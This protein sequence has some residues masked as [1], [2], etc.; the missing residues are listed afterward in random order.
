ML[1]VPME[2]R[3]FAALAASRPSALSIAVILVTLI[4]AT[5]LDCK[6][7]TFVIPG[8]LAS[9]EGDSSSN[10]SGLFGSAAATIQFQIT[11]PEIAVLGLNPG[12]QITGVR[13][14]LNG[15][16]ATAPASDISISS[17][18]ITLAQAALPF[19]SISA[20]FA[21]NLLKPVLVRSGPFKIPAGSMP[22][23][24]TPN[25]FGVL[26][27]FSTPYTYQG[28]DLVVMYT[29][30]TVS[31]T[32][33]ADAANLYAGVGTAYR[34]VVGAGYQATTGNLG[35]GI[36]VLQFEVTP[37][38]G[39]KNSASYAAG[40]LT[41]NTIAFG[42]SKAIAPALL[43][44]QDNP[45]PLLLG[46]VHLDIIDSQNQTRQAPL[47]FV[48]TDSLA[49]LVPAG[50]APG[51]ATA[52]LTTS[53]G[54]TVTGTINIVP[55]QPGIYSAKSSGTG[56]A[57]GLFIRVAAN[58]TQ[59]YGY[60][61]NVPD[62]TPL[63]VDLGSADDQVYLQLYGTGFRG[64]KQA[65]ATVGDI[66][67]PVYGF[68]AVAAY[69]GEDQINIGPLPRSLAGRGLVDVVVTF[70]GKTANTVTASIR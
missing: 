68:A 23:G 55:V 61:F 7:A 41:E 66:S 48:S 16:Q 45:W 25:A 10:T 56:V 43:V 4:V 67:V 11:A 53:T 20:T 42:E 34:N 8:S 36:A 40:Q 5:T 49:Y 52:K 22:G 6:A 46:G 51:R 31:P 58:G 44:A 63:P 59:S 70:D 18:D 14:R 62:L 64:A 39:N 9:T 21:N 2:S 50:T 12:D 57:A 1:Q 19:T 30:T 17:L 65:T 13:T 69:Q 27:P 38:F 28:G 3:S 26:V 54:V 60:L 37:I 29:K 15:G 32:F 33:T 35:T 24:S 47:Y